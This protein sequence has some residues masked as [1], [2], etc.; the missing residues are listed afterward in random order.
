MMAWDE[1][2]GR[3][4]SHVMM[5]QAIAPIRPPQTTYTS[6]A[7]GPNLGKYHACRRVARAVYLGSAPTATAA[8]RG[9]EDHEGLPA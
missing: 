2:V 3:A 4:M 9:V 5:S 1:L 6:T 7:L 8:N